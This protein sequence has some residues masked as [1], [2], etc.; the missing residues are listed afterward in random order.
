MSIIEVHSHCAV[1]HKL[2]VRMLCD[3]EFLIGISTASRDHSDLD[4][5]GSMQCSPQHTL[6]PNKSLVQIFL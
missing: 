3:F 4:L 6:K 2:H 5:A 1:N